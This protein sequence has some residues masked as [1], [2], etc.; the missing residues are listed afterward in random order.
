[1]LQRLEVQIGLG[2]G[3]NALGRIGRTRLERWLDT[4]LA[5]KF[6][7]LVV[8]AQLLLDQ[9]DVLLVDHF[10]NGPEQLLGLAD[11]PLQFL[12]GQFDID[13]DNWMRKTANG[14]LDDLQLLGREVH[15]Q[16]VAQNGPHVIDVVGAVFTEGIE[17][18]LWQVTNVLGGLERVGLGF[19]RIA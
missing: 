3:V 7:K 17:Q 12:P 2:K 15:R 8:A 6:G 19:T 13:F 11:L 4:L 1:M 10:T 18:L 16:H 14:A 5:K 9:F